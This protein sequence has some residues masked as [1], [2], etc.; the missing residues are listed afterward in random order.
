MLLQVAAKYI[1]WGW[2]KAFAKS[3]QLASWSQ[4]CNRHM[5]MGIK[6]GVKNSRY[7]TS[8]PFLLFVKSPVFFSP[9]HFPLTLSPL[10]PWSG[11]FLPPDKF[12]F[13]VLR[14]A[15]CGSIIVPLP[16]SG[17]SGSMNWKSTMSTIGPTSARFAIWLFNA[18]THYLMQFSKW[19]LA[20]ILCVG[21][22][23]TE[24]SIT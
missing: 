10:L 13:F 2:I 19:V 16:V 17:T 22:F 12:L 14:F 18:H 20:V 4:N 7:S 6:W 23:F 11:R 3:P 1:C 21:P 24:G 5:Y 8:D 15:V 9:R